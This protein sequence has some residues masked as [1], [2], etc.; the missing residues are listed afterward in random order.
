M[1]SSKGPQTGT[2]AKKPDSTVIA[3]TTKQIAIRL[4]D[5]EIFKH[6]VYTYQLKEDLNV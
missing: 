3:V 6:P 2:S 4:S 5:F 1:H